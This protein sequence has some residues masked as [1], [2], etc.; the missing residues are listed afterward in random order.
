[1]ARRTPYSS[2]CGNGRIL[3][4]MGGY[5]YFPNHRQIFDYWSREE[6][7]W[8]IA[9]KEA[10]AINKMLLSCSDEFVMRV[11]MCRLIIKPLFTHGPTKVEGVVN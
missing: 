9:T 4:G 5:D 11:S 2:L 6:Y 1:M 8:D 10:M 7:T 3:F